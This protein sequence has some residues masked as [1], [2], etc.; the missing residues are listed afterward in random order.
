MLALLQIL[1]L[2]LAQQDE[3]PELEEAEGKSKIQ[4]VS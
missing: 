4:E 2:I 1:G 3:L